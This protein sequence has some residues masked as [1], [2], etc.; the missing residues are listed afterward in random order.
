MG[1]IIPSIPYKSQE[2]PDAGKFRND[3]G[4]ACLAMVLN[5][6]G[7]KATTN[8][9]YRRTGAK[10]NGFV[11]VAQIIRAARTYG[12]PFTHHINWGISNLKSSLNAGKPVIPLVHYGAWSKIDP[13]KSTQSRFAGPH[14]VVVLGYDDKHIY[15]NDPLWSGSR[16][17]EGEHKQWTYQQFMAAW[18]SAHLDGN[19]DLQCIVTIGSL[20]TEK[21]GDNNNANGNEGRRATTTAIDPITLRRILAW[22]VFHNVPKPEI[23]IPAVITAYKDAMGNWGLRVDVHKVTENDTMGLIALQYYDNP[24]KYEAILEYNGLSPSDAI[25]DGDILIIPEPLEEPIA[26]PES[27]IPQGGTFEFKKDR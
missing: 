25:H 9:V 10:A 12:V 26:I 13:G 3:C 21:L 23:H 27:Q 7:K 20:P 4:P 8:A 5:G 24:M 22:S 14:F 19:R 15:V 1:I 2:D 18:E 6:F 17:Q 11:S 16:R